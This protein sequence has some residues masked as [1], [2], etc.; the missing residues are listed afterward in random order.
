MV[1]RT[2]LVRTSYRKV[3]LEALGE[4]DVTQAGSLAEAIR[5]A[6]GAHKPDG[7]A[8][9]LS[10]ERSFYRRLDLP[11]AAQK[12]VENVLGFELEATVPFE[13]EDAV[14]DYR[15]LKREAGSSTVAVFAAIARTDDVRE[16]VNLVRDALGQE[17][18]RVGTGALPLLN[19]SQVIPELEQPFRMASGAA[20]MPPGV[21]PVPNA[22]R[23]PV[24]IV[25]IG[26]TTSDVVI[27]AA[28][29]PIFAR[30]L[31]RG[32]VG[33]PG[34]APALAR[35]LRQS[36]GAFLASGGDKL[37]GMYLVGGGASVQGAELFLSTELGVS[38]L[39]LPTP[40]L[41]GLQPGQ[42]E[43]LPRYAKA[44]GL[45]LGLTGRPK[46]LNL[47]RGA[48]QAERRY[49][50]LR[51]KTPLLAGLAAVIV[52]SFGFSVMAEMRSLDAEHDVLIAKLAAASLDVLGEEIS[53]P[54]K[55]KQALE[56]GPGGADDDPM[57]RADAFDVMVKLS[58][59]VPRE[60]VHDVVEFDVNRSHV[61]IQGTVPS[62]PDAQGIAE[63]MKEHKCFKDVK[64]S[65][66]SQFG[67]GK[68]K[69]VLEFELKCDSTKKKK[70]AAGADSADSA[71][72]PA[73]T[74]KPE[75][76]K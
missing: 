21:V 23:G 36:L 70:P 45:A 55:A 76:L 8:I 3:T 19:L 22:I 30:T 57:P 63:K 14:Y 12:E 7:I 65:R 56:Q 58:E 35:E 53:D 18:E 43:L 4:S 16:R 32:T 34:S 67:E 69:Y 1:V 50:F 48:L 73:S 75:V 66:T 51:E 29:E 44:L 54:D 68:Q 40:K 62:I 26:E 2:A 10:G 60:V 42:A 52:V 15:M 11:A 20:G 61:T 41:E 17:P 46:G 49:P 27:M 25:D 72:A 64:I 24:A 38:I 6:V 28:G 39:P 33:L 9:A 59:A 37:A 47:R 74:T 13:M 71:A 31:S 5:A